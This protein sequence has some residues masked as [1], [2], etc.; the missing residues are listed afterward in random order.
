MRFA[1]A[2]SV[3]AAWLAL[4]CGAALGA[5]PAVI[6]LPSIGLA[7]AVTAADAAL[8]KC[9]S[10]GALV[11]VAVTDRSGTVLVVLRDPLA[12]PHTPDAATRKAW[13][14][15]SFRNATTAL[16]RATGPG[17]DSNGIR[18]LPGV[19]MVGGGIPVTA[20]GRQLGAIGVSGAPGGQ[21][22]ESCAKAGLAAI[23]DELELSR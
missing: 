13:T 8:Q 15:A 5:E 1:R 2:A 19:A 18:Q 21:I 9:R 23:Q 6:D 10:L 17:T 11:A 4:S 22:D 3:S 12:G 14:A 16:E 20:A 7:A